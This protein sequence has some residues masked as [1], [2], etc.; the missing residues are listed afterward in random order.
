M[1]EMRQAIEEYRIAE[2]L[3]NNAVSE[4]EIDIAIYKINAAQIKI[5]LISEDAKKVS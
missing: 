4:K 5:D 3:F 2:N 1:N